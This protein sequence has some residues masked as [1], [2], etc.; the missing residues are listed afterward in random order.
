MKENSL[1]EIS[2]SFQKKKGEAALKIAKKVE[3]Q[4]V[5][6]GRKWVQ[7]PNRTFILAK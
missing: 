3:K 7:G 1:A 5:L 2:I 6:E 4:L